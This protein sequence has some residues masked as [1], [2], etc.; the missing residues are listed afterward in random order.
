MTGIKV[1]LFRGN[2]NILSYTIEE[3]AILYESLLSDIHRDPRWYLDNLNYL[4][5]FK[6]SW[7]DYRCKQAPAPYKFT[8]K[9]KT[10]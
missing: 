1:R 7:H 9:G 5:Q 6:V 10:L 4:P 8:K 3:Q 2:S